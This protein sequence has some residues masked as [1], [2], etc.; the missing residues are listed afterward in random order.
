MLE[1]LYWGFTK[2]KEAEQPE[3]QCSLIGTFVTH[4]LESNI[5]KLATS[6]S[7]ISLLLLVFVAEQADFGM[8]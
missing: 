7:E 8:T 3:H 4:L 1:K 5:S 6:T 2:N